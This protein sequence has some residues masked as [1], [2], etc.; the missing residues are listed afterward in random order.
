MAKSTARYACQECGAVYPKWAGRCE[1]CGA[2]NSL[3]E[4]LQRAG[5]PKSLAGSKHSG[6]ALDFVAPLKTTKVLQ[7]VHAEI[8]AVSPSIQEDR[9][10]TKDF[11]AAAE[12]IRS[13][14]LAKAAQS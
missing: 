10:L 3:V 12:L 14:K 6:Q 4:E 13:G 1:A 11:A 5:P 8:R 7:R 2:W 9:V